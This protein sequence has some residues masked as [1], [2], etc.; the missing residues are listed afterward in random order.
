MDNLPGLP[1]VIHIDL[2]VQQSLDCLEQLSSEAIWLQAPPSVKNTAPEAAS[3]TTDDPVQPARRPPRHST[4]SIA[5]H[6]TGI[7]DIIEDT[8]QNHRPAHGKPPKQKGATHLR[9]QDSAASTQSATLTMTTYN[10]EFEKYDKLLETQQAQLDS[11]FEKA[12]TQWKA[13]ELQLTEQKTE[14][15]G[16]F[17]N[18]E[19]KVS[20][21]M[22]HMAQT[23][24]GIGKV[25]TKMDA[26]MQM[27]TTLTQKDSRKRP[28]DQ[29]RSITADHGR[30]VSSSFDANGANGSNSSLQNTSYSRHANDGQS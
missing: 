10:L 8:S 4:D 2:S 25:Q 22:K 16:R 11:G 21:T 15:N 9:S 13:L 30:P 27:F 14:Q 7:T 17:D 1:E 18:L 29:F 19:T 24:L 26:M 12:D 23:N 3:R 6:I 28:T 20:K 5:S